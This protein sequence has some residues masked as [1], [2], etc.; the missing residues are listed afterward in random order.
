VRGVHF[1]VKK[2]TVTLFGTIRHELDREL[3]ISLV[4]QLDGVKEV[5]EHLQI[6]DKPFQESPSEITLHL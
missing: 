6:A 4:A 5:V 2:G 1:Y 3:L